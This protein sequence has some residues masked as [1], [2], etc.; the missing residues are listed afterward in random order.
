MLGA[1]Q[2]FRRSAALSLIK[3][4]FEQP[5][6]SCRS[7]IRSLSGKSTIDGEGDADDEAGAGAAQPQ[8]GCGDLLALA[9]AADRCR[10][11][12]LGPRSAFVD[13]RSPQ[14][15]P[16]ALAGDH[17]GRRW[18]CPVVQ[19]APGNQLR[20]IVTRKLSFWFSISSIVVSNR[21]IRTMPFQ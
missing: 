4:C 21:P 10:G 16:A 18:A 8:D 14:V 20:S 13:G 15:G 9:E 12:S 1:R 6:R 11:G 17:R 2:T 19:A 7:Q 5:C 3:R